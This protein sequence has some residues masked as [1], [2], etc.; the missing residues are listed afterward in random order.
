MKLW[1]DDVRPA[2][3]GW[4]WATNYA[5]AIEAFE[6]NQITDASFDHDLGFYHGGE[7]V[8]WD[9]TTWPFKGADYRHSDPTGYD[10]IR[11]VAEC[12]RW[13]TKSCAVHSMNPVGF[14]NIAATIERYGPYDQLEKLVYED[15]KSEFRLR[16]VR[17]YKED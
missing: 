4:E 6:A 7:T 10:L 2:P 13:P 16:A 11:W 12:G 14:A 17:Y 3:E 9:H 8:T 1:I 15:P 5:D